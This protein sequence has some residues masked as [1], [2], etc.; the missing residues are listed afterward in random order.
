[1]ATLGWAKGRGRRGR[2]LWRTRRRWEGGA[3]LISGFDVSV[4]MCCSFFLEVSFSLVF[5]RDFVSVYVI[6][7]FSFS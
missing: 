2:Q 4:C 6:L 7:V 3:L 5:Y 1:M